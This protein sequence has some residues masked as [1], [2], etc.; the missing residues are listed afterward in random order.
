MSGGLD[1][2]LFAIAIVAVV[3]FFLLRRQRNLDDTSGERNEF[4]IRG[5]YAAA[6]RQAG[7]E[8]KAFVPIF[9]A[10]KLVGAL[11]VPL[12]VLEIADRRQW[13]VPVG[14]VVVSALLGFF[15]ADLWLFSVRRE[16]QKTITWSL[17]YLLDL[18]VAF[19][20]S[21][22]GLE[23]AFRRA[24]RDGFPPDHPLAQEVALVAREM[25]LGKDRAAAFR[26]LYAR[27]GV[28]PMKAIAAA[29]ESGL[30][31][32]ASV[33]ATLRAQ[34]ELLRARR[35]EDVLKRVQMAAIK[36]LVPVV[37][38]GLPLF[39]VIVFFPAF[40]EILRT[41]GAMAWAP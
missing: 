35:R 17:S 1:L 4:R 29:L 19:L 22:L 7:F 30:R 31:L 25:D 23:E 38:C 15:F 41:F 20:R 27:T 32:G 18:I 8:S 10:L 26:A 14:V 37:L 34:A 24:G 11:L 36:A 5:L 12:A 40:A 39:L 13:Q 2:L 33:E 3:G 16:R 21:G 28:V 9:W 6:V